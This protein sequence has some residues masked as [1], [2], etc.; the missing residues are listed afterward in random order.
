MSITIVQYTDNSLEPAFAARVQR[1]LVKAAEGKRII[2]VSQQPMDFGDNICMFGIGRNLHSLFLQALTGVK[3]ATTKYI[4]LAEHDCLYTP[5]H[6]NWQ[7]TDDNVFWYN[8]H[9]WFVNFQTGLYSYYRRKPMS[10]L[11]C[12]RELF[13]PAVEEKLA[14]L[15]TGFRLPNDRG[16]GVCEPGVIDG[17]PEFAAART[18]WWQSMKDVGKEPQWE[19]KAFGTVLA[20]V[21]IRHGTNYSGN[22]Y[23]P[24]M[25]RSRHKA[26]ELPYWGEFRQMWEAG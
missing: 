8:V 13:I 18:A 16:V 2:S 11:I 22:A 10:M 3:M 25:I 12:T 4:A 21:D 14:M 5:E 20:N 23:G 15:E 19:A 7:P 6:F 26:M 24:K 9:H 17:R 1:E